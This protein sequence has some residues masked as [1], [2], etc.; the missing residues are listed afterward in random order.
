MW[1]NTVGWVISGILGLGL[2]FMLYM[3][4]SPPSRTDP[5]GS[6]KFAIAYKPLALPAGADAAA[7]PGTKDCDAGEF[8]RKAIE[9]YQVTARAYE[10]FKTDRMNGSEKDMSGIAYIVEGRNCR[11][12]T[13]FAKELPKIV[14]YDNSE[15]PLEALQEIGEAACTFGKLYMNDKYAAEKSG[16]KL[17][18]E[19]A[20][21]LWEGTFVLGRHLYDERACW[22]EYIVGHGLMQTAGRNLADYYKSQNNSE[23]AD[24]I[25]T[26]LEDEGA[27]STKMIEAFKLVGAIDENYAGVYA[28]DIYKIALSPTADKMFRAEALKHIGNYRFNSMTRGDQL[29]AKKVL[30]DM[31]EDNDIPANVKAAANAAHELTI[32]KH[33]MI[34]GS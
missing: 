22:A 29:A 10:R 8:Y 28:G 15:P 33:N 12:G 34:G 17:Q 13:I 5:T 6:A 23:R 14:N 4:A 3:V 24:K 19:K 16:G 1:G 18:P 9:D 27:Q 7:A 11:N 21:A 31:V 20:L 26:F 2:S 30:K 25:Q 32:Q